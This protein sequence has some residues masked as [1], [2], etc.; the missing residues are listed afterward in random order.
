MLLMISIYLTGPLN[1]TN[2]KLIYVFEVSKQKNTGQ[3]EN[4]LV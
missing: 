2:F 4:A 1:N 3:I